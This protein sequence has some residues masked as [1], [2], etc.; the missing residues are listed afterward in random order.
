M[1]ND[2]IRVARLTLVFSILFAA[3]IVSPALLGGPFGPYP[4]M[5]VG[6]V[7]D[8]FTPLVLIPLYWLLFKLGGDRPARKS[9]T[10]LF[11]VLAA[12]WV[13][14]QG[15]HL[16]ANSIGHQLSHAKGSD[17]YGLTRF[18]DEHLS[19]YLWHIGLVGL[20]A[21]LLYR[22]WRYPFAG[23]R[24]GLRLETFPGMLYGFI[25]FITVVEAGTASLGV[26]FAVLVTVFGLI[27]GRNK[28]RQQP[29]LGFFFVAYLAAT[30]L[31]LGWAVYWGG[32]PEFSEVGI[33][34]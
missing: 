5:K 14:G 33:I 7:V 18:Y 9:E 22:Q 17:V 4:L 21:L 30:V 24:S 29:I 27:W 12:F 28:T 3:F 2:A 16:S 1:A 8:L 26:P 23:E 15:M 25:Y 10:I 11:V 31:F 34:E 32:L 6:D 20:S 13:E 19:H